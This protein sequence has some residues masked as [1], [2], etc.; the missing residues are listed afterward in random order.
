M[1]TTLVIAFYVDD[2]TIN[3]KNNWRALFQLSM[4][5]ILRQFYLS[6]RKI[7]PSYLSLYAYIDSII[8]KRCVT[9]RFD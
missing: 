3:L 5:E 2:Y 6:D 7:Q 1:I 8:V 4:I 9:N